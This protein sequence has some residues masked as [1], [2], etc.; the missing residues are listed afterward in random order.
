MSVP[1]IPPIYFNFDNLK[2]V[3]FFVAL[4]LSAVF[5]VLMFTWIAMGVSGGDEGNWNVT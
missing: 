1:L 4:V 2:E 5:P 3:G